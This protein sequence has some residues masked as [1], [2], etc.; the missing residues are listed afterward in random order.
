ME[1]KNA[2]TL[3]FCLAS[4]FLLR[5]FYSVVKVPCIPIVGCIPHVTIY[6]LKT[7]NLE[8][9]T[10]KPGTMS[11]RLPGEAEWEKAARGSD[12]QIYPWGDKPDPEKANY[13]DTGIGSTTAVGAFPGG[14]SPYGCLDMAGNVWE[15]TQSLWGTDWRKPDFN[16]PYRLDDGREDLRAGDNAL[17]VVR[18][19]AFDLTYRY[20]RC[21]VRYRLNPFNRY[22]F[23]GFR[24]CVAPIFP[25]GTR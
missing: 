14:V 13:E 23:C 2:S 5:K 25:L 15:W 22:R 12:G 18:G 4:K 6:D 9:R 19:G 8:P 20:V 21:A 11:V 3:I 1:P 10:L 16:Y 7:G 24:L 17:R